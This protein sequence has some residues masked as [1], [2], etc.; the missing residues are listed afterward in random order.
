VFPDDYSKEILVLVIL[1]V[2][3]F[4]NNISVSGSSPEI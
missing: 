1:V 3:L 4:R 2:P